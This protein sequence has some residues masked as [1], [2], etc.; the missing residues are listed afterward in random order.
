LIFTNVV[1]QNDLDDLEGLWWKWAK[2]TPM[3]ISAHRRASLEDATWNSLGYPKTGVVAKHSIGQSD[4][5]WGVRKHPNVR[6]VFETLWGSTD[7]VTS[8]DGCGVARNPYLNRQDPAKWATLTGWFH[9]DQHYKKD[10]GG[11][12][13][14]QGLLNFYDANKDTGSTVVVLGSHKRFKDNCSGKSAKSSHVTFKEGE[15]HAWDG[16]VQV[17]MEAGDF[18]VWDSRVVHC[19]Q[20]V[21][22]SAPQGAVMKGRKKDLLA[23]LVAYCCMIP[24]KNLHH[25][26]IER[27]QIEEGRRDMVKAGV[28]GTHDPRAIPTKGLRVEVSETYKAPNPRDPLWE[29]V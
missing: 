19:S 2:E 9:L 3:Q 11:L 1:P 28:T 29:L 5:M 13:A 4:F 7:L 17:T 10:G 14:Y 21:D 16:A 18:F 23:R 26:D 6:K 22:T 20:G 15:R 27:T 12:Q 24:R 25:Q 8:F